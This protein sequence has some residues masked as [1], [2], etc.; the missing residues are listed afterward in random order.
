MD[1]FK[2]TLR[3][4][5]SRI[6]GPNAL[7]ISEGFNYYDTERGILYRDENGQRFALANVFKVD[8]FD[9]SQYVLDPKKLLNSI[10]INEDIPNDTF[11]MYYVKENGAIIE[12]TSGGG[13][14]STYF[15]GDGIQIDIANII[16]VDSTILRKQTEN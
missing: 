4:P 7:P 1:K 13:G 12:L 15:A 10:I 16:S 11:Q 9:V 5:T 14:G 3:V 6:K 8:D 2:N